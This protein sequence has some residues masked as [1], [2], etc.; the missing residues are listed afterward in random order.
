[1]AQGPILI[2]DKSA[3]ESLNVDESVWLDN[4]Y[5]MNIT[6]L[7]Y[8]ETLADLEKAVAVRQA[9]RARPL[10]PLRSGSGRDDRMFAGRVPFSRRASCDG[11]SAEQELPLTPARDLI[12]AQEKTGTAC[13]VPVQRWGWNNPSVVRL[14][15]PQPH[16]ILDG[17]SIRGLADEA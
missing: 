10:P 7:F 17:K 5:L 11:K 2:F 9:Y 14:P 1:M 16:L 4:F 6:P 8:V 15:D 12:G 13:A 3:L